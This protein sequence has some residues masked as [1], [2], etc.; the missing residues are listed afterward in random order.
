[1]VDWPRVA[2]VGPGA[3]GSFFGGMLAR[4]GAPVAFVGRPGS[5]NPHLESVRTRGLA[6]DGV[7]IQETI[8]IEVAEPSEALEG[9]ELVLFGVKTPDTESAAEGIRPHLAPGAVVLSLQNGIDNVERM[10]TVGVEAIAAVVIVAAAIETPGTLRHRGRGDLVIGDPERPEE[11]RW[12]SELFERAGVPCEVSDAIRREL[13]FKLIINSMANATSAL[14]RASYRRLTEFEPTWRIALAVAREAVAVARVE[15]IE[16]DPE[17][18][19]A[20]GA[21][22]IQGV[23]EA[24]SSTEQDIARGRHTEIDALNG[25]IARRGAELD[26]PTPTNEILWALVKLR[27]ER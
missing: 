25:Y 22:I 12:I 13:W 10:R 26:V 2:V 17:E 9:A 24:T 14:T 7:A 23:G 4:A 1:M 15:G 16:L 20:R 18:L 6:F 21:A 3:V 11:A 5:T 8:P 27:E 19:I